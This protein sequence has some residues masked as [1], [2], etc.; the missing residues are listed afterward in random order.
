MCAYC[1]PHVWLDGTQW[2]DSSCLT[3]VNNSREWPDVEVF[4]S[5][6]MDDPL[7]N[8]KTTHSVGTGPL[9][10]LEDRKQKQ[11]QKQSESM[12]PV[13]PFMDLTPM[14]PKRIAMLNC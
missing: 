5:M 4:S 7:K 12:L 1:I 6:S 10:R 9:D 3:S 2:E 13:M 11:K 14:K 8:L